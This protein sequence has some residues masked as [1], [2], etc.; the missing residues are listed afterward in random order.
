MGLHLDWRDQQ[1]LEVGA[2]AAVAARRGK[3]LL[4]RGVLGLELHNRRDRGVVVRDIVRV[5]PKVRRKVHKH[6][7][8]PRAAL[9]LTLRPQVIEELGLS[10]ATQIQPIY[11][12]PSLPS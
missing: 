6:L 7:A 9:P 10:D 11:M 2:A 1:R 4:E 8:H 12:P 3:Q 5:H